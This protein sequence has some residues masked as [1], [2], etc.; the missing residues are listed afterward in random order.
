MCVFIILFICVSFRSLFW[1]IQYIVWS[2]PSGPDEFPFIVSDM[3]D[4]A[5]LHSLWDIYFY[6]LKVV[7]NFTFLCLTNF[8]TYSK[9]IGIHMSRRRKCFFAGRRTAD[10]R[11]STKRSISNGFGFAPWEICKFLPFLRTYRYPKPNLRWRNS[12]DWQSMQLHNISDMGFGTWIIFGGG[13]GWGCG[14]SQTRWCH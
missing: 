8:S 1:P 11:F 6:L 9:T 3:G 14:V 12:K 5:L 7:G 10:F 13:E 4:T 2:R